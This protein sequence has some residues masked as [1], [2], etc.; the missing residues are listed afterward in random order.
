MEQQRSSNP[1]QNHDS[2]LSKNEELS[3]SEPFPPK[4]SGGRPSSFDELFTFYHNYVKVLY[5]DVQTENRLPQELLFELNA[6]LDHIARFWT[7]KEP[8][9]VVVRRAF[10]H[11]KRA[12]LDVFK[13]RLKTASDQYTRLTEVEISLIDNGEFEKKLNNLFSEIKTL[14]RAARRKEGRSDTENL[15]PAFDAWEGVFVKCVQLEED[16][17]S[18]KNVA[19]ARKTGLKA[20]IRRNI[21]A[22]CVGVIS[23]LA[24]TWLFVVIAG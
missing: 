23:S 2:K 15:I 12:C 8:E 19:W 9:D 5:A 16:F 20:L 11:F 17:F 13:L 22:F 7:Y 6:G 18:S 10:G 24:A 4:W 21:C 14:A 1:P 3:E